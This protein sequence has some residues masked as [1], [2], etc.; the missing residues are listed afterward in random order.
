MWTH[1]VNPTSCDAHQVWSISRGVA[2]PVSRGVNQKWSTPRGVVHLINRGVHQKW[3]TPR[4]V[5]HA[6]QNKTIPEKL[7]AFEKVLLTVQ[8]SLVK[9]SRHRITSFPVIYM[10]PSNAQ[11]LPLNS[12]RHIFP[13]YKRRC[14]RRKI[15]WRSKGHKRSRTNQQGFLIQIL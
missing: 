10:A 12:E 4:V 5:V 1:V 8:P 15:G 7:K 3:L 14:H 2:H 9:E 13:R 6:T 11:S